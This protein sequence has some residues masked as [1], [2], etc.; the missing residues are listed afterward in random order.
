MNRLASVAVF[1]GSSFGNNPVYREKAAELGRVLA[2]SGIRLVYGVGYRGLMGVIAESVRQSGGKVTGVLPKVFDDP[3]VRLKD[4]EDELIIASGMHERKSMMYD[5]S[6]AF[7]IFPG[8]IGTLDEFFEIFTWR[9]IG[10]HGKNIALYNISGYFDR[11]LEF[12]M[13]CR[14]R[15]FMKQEVLSSLIVSDDAADIM[16]QLR[17][18][19]TSLPSKI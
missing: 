6:D 1:C 14:D 10:L 2:S 9:Q 19:E 16:H 13:E 12:L 18:K 5:R 3:R 4:V 8:G 7:I 11:L 17:V 15:G